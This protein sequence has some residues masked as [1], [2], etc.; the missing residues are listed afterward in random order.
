MPRYKWKLPVR[1]LPPR[2]AVQID[3][4]F[5]QGAAEAHREEVCLL[6]TGANMG[7]VTILFRGWDFILCPL[8]SLIYNN[9]SSDDVDLLL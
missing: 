2:N 4:A 3:P 5:L 9:Y 6:M 7:Y 1:P 8:Q